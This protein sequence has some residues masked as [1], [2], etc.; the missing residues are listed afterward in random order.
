MAMEKSLILKI[1][2]LRRMM[3]KEGLANSTIMGH[4]EARVIE[5]AAGHFYLS[6]LYE[7]ILESGAG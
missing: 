3:R 7:L 6:S 4:C 5:E 1:K 2:F